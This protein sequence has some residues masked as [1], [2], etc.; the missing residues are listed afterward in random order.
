M[1]VAVR[2]TAPPETFRVDYT[3]GAKRYQG[4]LSTLPDGRIYVLPA[5]WHIESR[6][7]VD[8][9]EITPIPDGAHD[10]R[11][12]WNANCFNC[13]AT[14]IVAGLRRRRRRRTSR[15]GPRWASAARRVT[16]PGRQHVALMDAWEKDP[17]SK[18]AYDNSSKNRAAERHPEDLLATQLASR[19]ASTTPAPTATAT[20]HNVFVGFKGGDRYADYALPF[21][22][23]DADS[24]QRSAGRVLARRPAQSLQPPAGADAERLLQGRR[25]RVHEL[26]RRPRLAQRVLAE[27]EHQPGPQRRCAVHAVPLRE[28]KVGKP[29]AGTGTSSRKPQAPASFTG[30]G[31]EAHTFHAPESAGSRCIS[32][33]MSDVN[34]RLLIRRR[35]HT[36]QPPVP[37][38]TAQFGVP[39]RVHDVSR[40]SNAR[41]GG[42]ADGRVVGRRR[43]PRAGGVA[44]RHDVSRRFGRRDDAAGAGA[45]GGR[46]IAGL[47]G[48]RERGRVHRRGSSRR[49]IGGTSR[50]R[51]D[52]EPDVV[53]RAVP[54]R[55]VRRSQARPPTTGERRRRSRRRS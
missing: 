4:Y 41:V 50:E 45:A 26:P 1:R 11:Q 5:F 37:E 19:G 29:G 7:W 20:R 48:P 2:R 3:L 42:E 16:G 40:R 6:R 33:H 13:H 49:P 21:L 8:W 43:A 51:L 28:P 27:G 55:A 10:L 23:S 35:D 39:E 14:N 31:L 44:R 9:K 15:R 17:A 22:I 46:S 36:F 24:R 34:W 25:D 30:A 52:A 18:P 32:C 47:P 53:R 38:N 12:I 54:R